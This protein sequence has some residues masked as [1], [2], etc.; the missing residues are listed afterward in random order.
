M[1]LHHRRA[2]PWWPA[3]E[4]WPPPDRAWMWRRRRTRFVGGIALV[5]ATLLFLAATGAVSLVMMMTG[6][7]PSPRPGPVLFVAILLVI[8]L[9]AAVRRVGVPLGGIVEAANR[10]ASGDFST[11]V[12]EKGPPSARTV[13]RAFNTMAAQLEL[14]DRQR[15]N[16]MADV[17]HELRTPLS[18]IQGRLEGVLD[19]V[20]P[21][22]DAALEQLLDE[23]H[24]LA[25]LIED[26]R[27]LAN[28]ESGTL[29]LQKEPADV[30]LLLHDVAAAFDREAADRGLA[31]RVQPAGDLPLISVDPL[32]LREVV[33]NLVSNALRHTPHGGVVAIAARR[34]GDWAILSV[35][36]TG[37]GIPPEDLP[38]IFDRFYKGA[39]SR[40]SGLGLTIARNLVRAHGGQVSAE[41]RVGQGTTITVKLPI[42]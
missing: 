13:S 39:G 3:N 38:K 11:R 41:S 32:R 35:A 42:G 19:G 24:L 30:A 15:R 27:T 18:V 6:G 26:L 20:Y 7:H 25:R 12:A 33:A 2:P 10:I 29:A 40:G 14:Q 1:R 9:V 16:L 17:A 37:S 8:A 23:T 36:D 34:D 22:D 5:F 28:A 4:P 31:I 21:R